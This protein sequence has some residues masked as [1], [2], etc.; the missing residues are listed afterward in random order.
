MPGGKV[1]WG[2]GPPGRAVIA[3]FH[4]SGER[5]HIPWPSP[6]L[7]PDRKDPVL[8]RTQRIQLHPTEKPNASKQYPFVVTPCM[9]S[10]MFPK[11]SE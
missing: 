7:C 1:Q 9:S 5:T 10:I 3:A 11:I 2:Q 8:Y 4:E 6:C